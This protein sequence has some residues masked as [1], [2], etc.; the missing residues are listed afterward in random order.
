[1]AISIILILAVLWA[2]F[3]A[4]PLVQRRFSGTRRDSI[5][6]FSKRLTSIGRVGG[7]APAHAQRRMSPPPRPVP[8]VATPSARPAGLPMSAAAQKRRRDALAV[9]GV[10]VLCTLLLAV[11][12]GSMLLWALQ[13]VTDLGFVAYVA[14]LV[15]L[16]RKAQER[17]AS[18]HFLTPA[19]S[20]PSSP[21]VL[22]RTASS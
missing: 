4:W 10:A 13:I 11:V 2:A 17:R 8:F 7:H 9:L 6:D 22:R 19:V 15:H 18:V 5:G 14:V 3:F 12:T 20:Q 21:M 16:R 1:M